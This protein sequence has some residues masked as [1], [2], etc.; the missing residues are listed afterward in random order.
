MSKQNN[1]I[2]LT[3]RNNYNVSRVHH[4]DSHTRTPFS[5]RF[6]AVHKFVPEAKIREKKSTNKLNGK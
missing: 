6:H 3:M 4:I 2:Q 1:V 5:L